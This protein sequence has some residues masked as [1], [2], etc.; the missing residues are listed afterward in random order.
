MW[1]SKNI[2]FHQQRYTRYNNRSGRAARY[3][4][5]RRSTTV[6][7]R[8]LYSTIRSSLSIHEIVGYFMVKWIVTNL[9]EIIYNLCPYI[10]SHVGNR[11][12]MPKIKYG[13][14]YSGIQ[15]SHGIYYFQL[16]YLQMLSRYSNSSFI[17]IMNDSFD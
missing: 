12:I 5:R 1:Y 3:N 4:N 2:E 9:P 13:K 6:A 8:Y 16:D 17:H 7:A 14:K 15:S 10:E 11:P